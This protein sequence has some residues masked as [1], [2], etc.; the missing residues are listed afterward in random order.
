ML[1]GCWM[2]RRASF[3]FFIRQ[4]QFAEV[5]DQQ[6][7]FDLNSNKRLG[8]N[9]QYGKIYTEG[10]GSSNWIGLLKTFLNMSCISDLVRV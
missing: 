3:C 6:I 5:I 1:E 9:D 10:L 4:F 7:L 8:N 2:M